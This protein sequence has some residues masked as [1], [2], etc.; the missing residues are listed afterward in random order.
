MPA[1]ET[2]HVDQTPISVTQV[3][4]VGAAILV[5]ALTYR[6]VVA[7]TRIAVRELDY[8]AGGDLDTWLGNRR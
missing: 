4:A 6:A 2:S 3:S 8:R 1:D 7:V 5:A